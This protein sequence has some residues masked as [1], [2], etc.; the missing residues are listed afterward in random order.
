M[1]PCLI[2]ARILDE[3]TNKLKNIHFLTFAENFVQ[4]AEKAENYCGD[5]ADTLTIELL[6]E[7][8]VI[9]FGPMTAEHIR[10][11]DMV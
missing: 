10:K 11:G 2:T 4:A 5:V 7:G 8:E 3:K 1:Y 9:G 6:E